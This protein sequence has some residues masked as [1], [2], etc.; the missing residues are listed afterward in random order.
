[1]CSRGM[2]K[3]KRDAIP[4]FQIEMKKTPLLSQEFAAS[5]QRDR[6]EVLGVQEE[7]GAC[8]D[9]QHQLQRT[10]PLPSPDSPEGCGSAISRSQWEAYAHRLRGSPT[11]SV[12]SQSSA[13]KADTF[14]LEDVSEIFSSRSIMFFF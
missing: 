6:G 11:P 1:M 13:T 4:L 8:D 9:V 2:L 3:I 5:R 10:P 14:L 7:T 12:S